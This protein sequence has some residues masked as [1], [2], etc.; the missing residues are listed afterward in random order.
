MQS[1]FYYYYYYYVYYP[2]K[3]KKKKKTYYDVLILTQQLIEKLEYK[4][5]CLK[6]LR[7]F[8][9]SLAQSLTKDITSPF[10]NVV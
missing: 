6:R 4:I 5:K 2:Q 7:L 8:G 9:F 10:G 1:K 3:K